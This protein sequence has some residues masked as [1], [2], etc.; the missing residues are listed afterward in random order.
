MISINLIPLD[1]RKKGFPAYKLYI[2]GIYLVLAITLVLWAYNLFM[3][4]YNESK[5]NDVQSSLAS[6]HLWQERYNLIQ[7]QN[8][9]IKKREGIIVTLKKSRM[10]W[11]ESLAELG[12]ITPY[13]CWLTSVS[14]ATDKSNKIT[15]E[16]SALKM[17]QLLTFIANLQKDPTINTVSL[18][19]TQTTKVARENGINIIKFTINISKNG[20][21][22]DAK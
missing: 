18:V 7:L 13:G 12:N 14:Q 9:D 19:S 8:A 16:G 20:G 6:M 22:P 1:R 3:F 5:L 21:V 15:I 17:E 11:S 10:L 2:F 4:K